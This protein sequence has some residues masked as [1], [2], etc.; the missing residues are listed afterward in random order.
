VKLIKAIKNEN[1]AFLKKIISPVMA[2]AI[3]ED[4]TE[5]LRALSDALEVNGI[6][7]QSMDTAPSTMARWDGETVVFNARSEMLNG[8]PEFL[9]NT[10]AGPRDNSRSSQMPDE[11]GMDA[12]KF[13][14]KALFTKGTALQNVNIFNK[15]NF[16]DKTQLDCV[17]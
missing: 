15:W 12:I 5:M 9:Q 6:Y 16:R 7:H 3:E 17:V 2:R 8:Q 10:L 1:L 13:L 4:D 14:I 11:K